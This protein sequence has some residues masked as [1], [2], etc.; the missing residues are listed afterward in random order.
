MGDQNKEFYNYG[1]LLS[2]KDSEGK[3]PGIFM[4]EGNRTGG[5]TF[6]GKKRCMKR[7]LENG[8][9]F[10]LI[11]R[12]GKAVKNQYLPFGADLKTSWILDGEFSSRIIEKDLVA[13]NFYNDKSIGYT[14]SIH[15]PG[16]IKEISS[17]FVDVQREFFDEFQEE[18]NQYLPKEAEKLFSV[19]TSI[20][21][22]GGGHSRYVELIMCANQASM[23]N[24]YYLQF[25]LTRRIRPDSKFVKAPGVVLERCYIEQAADEIRNSGIGRAYQNS[26]QLKFSVG[27]EYLL[28]S[29]NLIKKFGGDKQL[30]MNLKYGGKLFGIWVTKEGLYYVSRKNNPQHPYTLAGTVRDHDE[31]TVFIKYRN[32]TKMLINA[33]NSGKV[34]FEDGYCKNVFFEVVGFNN[35]F[36]DK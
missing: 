18:N 2:Q 35:Y 12:R 5:K 7:F 21:R 1:N 11:V 34:F 26:D 15:N 13:E 20:A 14:I 32:Y 30:I 27:E 17:M 29:K 8:E 9:K 19:H 3:K 23:Y 10:A 25:D 22:G 33:F 4:V 24:P 6:G 16:R 28:D 36:T 31:N